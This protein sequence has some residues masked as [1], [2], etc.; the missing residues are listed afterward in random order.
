MDLKCC[1]TTLLVSE[2]LM[3]EITIKISVGFILKTTLNKLSF[4]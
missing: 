3:S 2:S 1:V 4:T